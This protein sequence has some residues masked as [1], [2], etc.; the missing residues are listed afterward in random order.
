MREALRKH[1][2]SFKNAFAGLFWAIRTQPN[3]RVHLFFSV[4]AIV[5]GL[6]LGISS[7]EMTIII[8][9]IVLGLT[10]EMVNTSIESMTDLITTEWHTQ[11]KIAKDVSAGMML[12]AAIG[13]FVVGA[14]VLI[15]HILAYF[16]HF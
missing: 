13:A 2:I 16:S 3:F 1:H 5:L 15:P 7:I 4:C 10:A 8:L 9:T 14:L 12:V 11:A 6:V